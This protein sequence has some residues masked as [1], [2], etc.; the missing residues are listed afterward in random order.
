MVTE[1]GI[2]E[3][4]GE[5]TKKCATTTTTTKD[6]VKASFSPSLLETMKREKK[7]EGMT[8][9]VS[10]GDSDKRIHRVFDAALRF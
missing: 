3:T 1:G 5:E 8:E 2:V 7:V 6:H 9:T 10:G 4:E